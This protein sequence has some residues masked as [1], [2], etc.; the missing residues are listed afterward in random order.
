M[1]LFKKIKKKVKKT[2]KKVGNFAGDIADATKNIPGVNAFTS[3]LALL[4]DPD[5]FLDIWKQN[6]LPQYAMGAAGALGTGGLGGMLGQFG[7][8]GAAQPAL[9]AGEWVLGNT[10]YDAGG[11]I[12]RELPAGSSGGLGGVLGGV[13]GGSGGGYNALAMLGGL[14]S[15]AGGIYGAHTA[16]DA[17]QAQLQ[18]AREA[19]ALQASMYGNQVALQEPFRQAGMAGQNRLLDLLGLS[20]NTS[21]ADFGKYAKDFQMSDFQEDPGY[22][23]RLSEGL[24]GLDRQA[25][26][27]GGLISGAAL[28]AA[29]RYGQD[30]ASEEY[31]NAFNR[32]QVNRANQLNPLQ[33]LAGQGQT[34]ANTLT[35]ASQN[36][37]NSAGNLYQGMGDSRASGY[38]GSANALTGGLNDALRFYQ[39]QQLINKYG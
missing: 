23:F 18:A 5:K 4:D 21:G 31:Q 22:K 36:Y 26:A 16:K 24:K 39:N 2:V 19:L 11:N 30:A 12:V 6:I 28:K 14:G 15:L 1:G 33:S 29:Q 25:A 7:L 32:Y 17:S 38:I 13:L 20:K 37:A 3:Q 27:R 8:G 34:T 35:N 10:V 9:G